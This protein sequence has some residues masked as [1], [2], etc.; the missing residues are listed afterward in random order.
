MEVKSEREQKAQRSEK[1]P[2]FPGVASILLG[3]KKKSPLET[4][5][6]VFCRFFKLHHF[7]IDKNA[8]LFLF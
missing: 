2:A 3:S 6:P 5:T 8:V 1:S 7:G 4:G